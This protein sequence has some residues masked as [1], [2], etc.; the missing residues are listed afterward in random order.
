MRSK[1]I[2]VGGYYIKNEEIII[3]FYRYRSDGEACFHAY[4]LLSGRYKYSSMVEMGTMKLWAHR[5]AT[6]EEIACL[7]PWKLDTET[8]LTMPRY[9]LALRNALRSTPKGGWSKL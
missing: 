3:H 4:D 7:Q 8:D 2:E 9:R 1:E 6:N 5:P